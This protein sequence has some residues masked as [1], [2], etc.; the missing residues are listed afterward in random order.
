M[1]SYR[2]SIVARI[3]CDPPCL[4]WSGVG[5]LLIPA[6]TVIPEAAIALGGSELI[7]IPDFQTLINGTAERLDFTVSGVS[8][9]TVRLAL[10]DAPSV[11]GARVDIG[12]IGFDENWQVDYVEW[13][14]V[15]EA[16]SLTVSRPAEQNGQITRSITLTIVQGDTTRA[17]AIN[18]FFTDADQRSKFPTDA[19]FSHVA[20]INAGTSR[21]FGPK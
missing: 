15:F 18:A 14:G 8:E 11:K 16:R 13:E 20:G 19:I 1:A 6:D 9:E 21:R 3:A 10:D 2:E 7:S 4:L 17:R 12:I 5:P